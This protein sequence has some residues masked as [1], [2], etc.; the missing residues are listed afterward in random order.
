VCDTGAAQ[1]CAE[2]RCMRST[3]SLLRGNCAASVGP[4]RGNAYKRGG[5][6]VGVCDRA[7]MPG[8]SCTYREM[9]EKVTV[10]NDLLPRRT[11]GA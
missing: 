3:V 9:V 11:T 5:S 7:A 2:A 4:I 6:G 1:V 8:A 10:S